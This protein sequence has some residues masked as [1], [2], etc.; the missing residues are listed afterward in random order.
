MVVDNSRLRASNVPIFA[1]DMLIHVTRV[2]SAIRVNEPRTG[3][4]SRLSSAELFV[5]S[6]RRAPRNYA[7][8]RMFRGT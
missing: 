5:Q 3:L 2:S 1:S 7:Q 8:L 6:E 4:A